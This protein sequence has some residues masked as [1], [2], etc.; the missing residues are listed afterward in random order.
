VNN[1]RRM[2]LRSHTGHK[3]APRRTHSILQK[4]CKCDLS[5][6]NL[7]YGVKCLFIHPSEIE[8]IHTRHLQLL[9]T[10]KATCLSAQAREEIKIMS[11]AKATGYNLQKGLN[12]IH[13]GDFTVSKDQ[14]RYRARDV[15]FKA[16]QHD[17]SP[18]GENLNDLRTVSEILQNFRCRVVLLKYITDSDQD[19]TNTSNISTPSVSSSCHTP[20][21]EDMNLT[22][23]ENEVIENDSSTHI[24]SHQLLEWIDSINP[25]RMKEAAVA[26]SWTSRPQFLL[27]HAFCHTIHVDATHKV[28][29]IDNLYL[30]TLT[31]RDRHGN[32]YVVAWF[33]IPNQ[34]KWMFRYIFLEA[35][36]KLFGISFC[37]KVRAIV[38][39]GDP[40]LVSCIESAIEIHYRKAIHID[41]TW[42]LTDRSIHKVHSTWRLKGHVSQFLSEWFCRFFQTWLGSLWLGSFMIPGRGIEND[43]EYEVSKCIL[44]GVINSEM[45]SKIFTKDTVLA[46]NEFLSSTIFPKER[47][48]LVTK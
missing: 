5:A 1:T 34:R 17:S 9:K 24:P 40:Q 4:D 46:I 3:R 44:L 47:S 12:K 45:I 23:F 14:M 13:K 15:Q 26:I 2:A 39:D 37:Q 43:E 10:E 32:T 20:P 33:W 31:V 22:H 42:H 8:G 7:H 30:F 35:I 27:A 41:C 28:C 6:I 36:P 18:A 21:S 29:M 25:G 48:Y 19:P 38:S 16:N 11:C